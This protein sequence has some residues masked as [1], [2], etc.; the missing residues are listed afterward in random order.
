[1]KTITIKAKLLTILEIKESFKKKGWIFVS[2]QK[3]KEKSET[4]SFEFNKENKKFSATVFLSFDSF[5]NTKYYDCDLEICA[6]GKN[7]Y[8]SRDGIS[9]NFKSI[10]GIIKTLNEEIRDFCEE[11]K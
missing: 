10:N 4:C 2:K 7:D 8:Y 3:S 6:K 9:G 1:M 5:K 11:L